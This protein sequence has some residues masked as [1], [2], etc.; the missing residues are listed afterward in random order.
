MGEPYLGLADFDGAENNG[1]SETPRPDR[2]RIEHGQPSLLRQKRH[3]R[4]SA[5]NHR[6]PCV[7]G[8]LRRVSTDAWASHGDMGEKESQ[9]TFSAAREIDRQRIG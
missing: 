2:A 4:V 6:G 7:S 5:Y 1:Q 3:V 9:Y 8:K